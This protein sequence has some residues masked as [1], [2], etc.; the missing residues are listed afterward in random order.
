MA[1]EYPLVQ[2]AQVTSEENYSTVIRNMIQEE[3]PLLDML[4]IVPVPMGNNQHGW[5]EETSQG[6]AATRA[7]NGS[8]TPSYARFIPKTASLTIFGGEIK[9]DVQIPRLYGDR[10]PNFLQQQADAKARATYRKI[11]E[12][13]YEGDPAVDPNTFQGFRILA[14]ERGMEFDMSGT[15]S[16]DAT[17]LTLAKLDEVLD[18]VWGNPFINCNQWTRRKINALMRT[19]GQSREMVDGGFGRQFESY[20]GVPIVINQRRNDLTTI[21]GFDEDPGDGGDDSASLYVVNPIG[22][23]EDQGVHVIIGAGSAFEAY[24]LG[25]DWDNPQEKSRLEATVGLVHKGNRG[26]ARLRAIGQI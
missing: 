8:W 24:G 22:P 25:E 16:T 4:P 13:L 21:L 17:E 1:N 18:A 11:E 5:W 2:A 7:I 12:N 14:G 15:G 9:W 19:A 3:N 10:M 23:E 6:S 20:A 26:L